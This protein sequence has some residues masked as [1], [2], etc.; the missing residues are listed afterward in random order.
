MSVKRSQ[1]KRQKD[2]REKH[3]PPAGPSFVNAYHEGKDIVF[4]ERCDDGK[5]K[6]HRQRGLATSFFHIEDLSK[7]FLRMLRE[8]PEVRSITHEDPWVRVVWRGLRRDIEPYLEGFHA[9]GI[10]TYEGTINP[11][12]RYVAD[13]RVKIVRPRCVFLDIETDSDVPILD[14]IEG[15]ARILCWTL[16]DT[17]GNKRGGLLESDTDKAEKKLLRKLWHYLEDYDQVAAWNG[18]RFD[19]PVIKE[20][21]KKHKIEV[22]MRRHLWL[23][24]LTLFKRYNMS[25]A[26]S[27][28]EKQSFKLDAIASALLGEGKD[29]FDSSRTR[30][31]YDQAEPCESGE[32]GAC[33]R[34]LIKYCLK[35]TDLLRRIEDTT[36]FIELLFNVCDVTG[37][38]PDSRGTNPG[39]FVEN[40]LLRV[41][42]EQNHHF[43]TRWVAPDPEGPYDGAYVMKPPRV[44]GVER[45]VHVADFAGLY[46]SIIRTWNM[47][48]EKLIDGRAEPLRESGQACCTTAT[49]AVF[50]TKGKGILPLALERI[51]QLRTKWKKLAGSLPPGTHEWKEAD[52]RSKGY[53]IV[54]NSFYGV[55]GSPMGRMYNRDV[56]E[57]VTQCGVFLIKLT[58]KAAEERGMKVVYGDTDSLFVKGETEEYFSDFVKWCNEE[59]YPTALRDMGCTENFIDLGYEKMF[60]RLVMTKAKKYAGSYIHYD[61]TRATSESKPEIKGLEFKRGDTA[62]FAR[63]FQ[64]EVVHKLVGYKVDAIEDPT[65]MIEV[66]ERWQ[67]KILRQPLT[68]DEVQITKKLSKPLHEYKQREK[69]DGNLS[70]RLPHVEIAAKLIERGED[71]GPGDRISYI[72]TDGSTTPKQFAHVDEAFDDKG[73]LRVDRFSLWDELVW[74]HTE[75]VLVA[76]FPGFDWSP[77]SKTRPKTP[78][79]KKHKPAP[80]EQERL[81]WGQEPVSEDA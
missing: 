42:A 30:E 29:P 64:E 38:F 22:N 1:A 39:N 9:K 50:S 53:K 66:V 72:L 2:Q 59:L 33:R 63:E 67:D 25:A 55:I 52:R 60:D 65:D 40:Y 3:Q 57:A 43:P 10:Q 51:T 78:R 7:G 19:F 21:T 5:V 68:L 23:D 41:G 76:A 32:C 28:D 75:R 44:H 49:R 15:K 48:P 13:H 27:G 37:A 62:K 14:A 77:W 61:G 4:V 56:A 80:P 47:S 73:E 58:M 45:G 8:A 74:P 16:V 71:I 31:A 6:L 54:A 70:L 46:P 26:E 17:N 11:I 24:Q 12:R 36:G 79:K 34:C 20:R 18:D 35:D 69:K 81:P